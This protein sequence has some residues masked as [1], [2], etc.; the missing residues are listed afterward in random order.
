MVVMN[1]AAMF[2]FTTN[3][4]ILHKLWYTYEQGI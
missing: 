4:E 1:F 3:I 2:Y